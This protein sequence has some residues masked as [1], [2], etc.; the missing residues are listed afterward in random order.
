M[1]EDKKDRE[2]LTTNRKDFSRSKDSLFRPFLTHTHISLG[3]EVL[4]SIEPAGRPEVASRL[5]ETGERK[6]RLINHRSARNRTKA[7]CRRAS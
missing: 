6:Q 3:G 5:D 1:D 7:H 2:V 4:T